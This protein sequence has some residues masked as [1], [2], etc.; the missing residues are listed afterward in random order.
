VR[1]FLALNA[2]V[3][4]MMA[5]ADHDKIALAVAIVAF[6]ATTFALVPVLQ[7]VI[8]NAAPDAP[9]LASSV[10]QGAFNVANALGAWLGGVAI[11][12]GFGYGSP[13]IVASGLA[14]CALAIAVVAARWQSSG[15]VRDA[16]ESAGGVMA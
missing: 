5:F 8:I 14:V 16:K 13:T 1:V 7:S 10:N 9:N 3:A 4:A 6:A 11:S 15:P 2:L 12:A